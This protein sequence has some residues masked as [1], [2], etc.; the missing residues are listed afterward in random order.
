MTSRPPS[1]RSRLSDADL[2]RAS[3]RNPAAFDELYERTA[4]TIWAF[5]ERRT[6]DAHASSELCAETFARAW[7][8]RGRFSTEAA[9]AL[10]W[11]IGIARMVMRESVRRQRYEQNARRRLG[12]TVDQGAPLPDATWIEGLD[13]ALEA[14]PSAQREA[15]AL[16][17]E[18][19]LSFAQIGARLD[20]PAA[21]ARSRVHRGLVFLRRHVQASRPNAR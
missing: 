21:T 13:E 1:R 2:V 14:L 12:M 17:F 4:P 16:R 3:R 10:P 9:D 18:E 19:D 15:L 5:C 11:L 6:H 7:R 8:S 20:V